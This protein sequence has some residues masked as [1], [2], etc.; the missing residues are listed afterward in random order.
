M[1]PRLHASRALDS[2]C[3]GVI[4]NAPLTILVDRKSIV[5]KNRSN[6]LCCPDTEHSATYILSNSRKQ[7]ETDS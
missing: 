7:E 5:D 3:T 2:S 4:S 6:A 1:I